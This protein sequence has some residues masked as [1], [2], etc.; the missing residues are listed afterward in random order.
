MYASAI[1]RDVVN[2]CLYDPTYEEIEANGGQPNG[3]GSPV[4]Y[5]FFIS[6]ELLVAFV[7]LNL[8]VAVILEGFVES[9]KLEHGMLTGN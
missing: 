5:I 8:F 7:F 2:D 9:E 6:F 3:C 1:E 4:A